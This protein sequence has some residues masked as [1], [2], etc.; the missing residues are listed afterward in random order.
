MRLRIIP[1]MTLELTPNRAHRCLLFNQ[2][3]EE[4]PLSSVFIRQ[5]FGRLRIYPPAADLG[6][7]G[8]YPNELINDGDRNLH[9]I[10][11]P[12][13]LLRQISKREIFA[14]KCCQFFG[15]YRRTRADTRTSAF[16]PQSLYL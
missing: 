13:E 16:R 10:S 6:V 1:S 14:A 15:I 5:I 2:R 9:R 12:G 3:L 8:G 7:S 11:K 4:P